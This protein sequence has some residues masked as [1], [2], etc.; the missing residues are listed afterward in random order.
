ME[1]RVVV[2]YAD[3]DPVK[4]I[5]RPGPHQIY[6][7][8]RIVVE[9]RKLPLLRP[10]EIRV[11]M[12]YAGICGTDIHLVTAHPDTGYIRCSAPAQITAAGRIIGHEGI[13]KVLEVGSQVRHIQPGACVTFESII[14]CHYCDECRRGD[15]N[16]CRHA[17]LLGLEKDGL[18]GDI[19]DVP[20]MI[21]H[22]VSDIAQ[23]EKG[24]RAAACIE[25]AGV[26][27]V[28]CQNTHVG[29]GDVV[30]IF[31]AGPI[32]LF[33]AMLSKFVFGASQVHMVEPVLFRRKLAEK[34]SNEIYD[35]DEFF[36]HGPSSIDVV[37]EASG[38]M[39][40]ISRVFRRLNANG[41]V[42]ILGRSGE[43]LSLDAVDHMITNAVS[44][45]GSRG[46][47]GGAFAKILTLCRNGRI[48]LDD[49]VTCI[50]NGPD[51]I[52]DLLNLPEKILE[53]NCKVLVNFNCDK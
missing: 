33:A 4:G 42:A 18:F 49:A 7:N 35:I 3:I 34:W 25:P 9:K 47:L 14:V 2:V 43:P 40:N 38:N 11:K 31:G 29:A 21:T 32:G 39:A 24:M 30:A 8:P 45:I 6:K 52:S 16:Q 46:H 48:S 27:Y 13:G 17:L 26:A 41:R 10:D 12:L 1:S 51:E 15:F 23:N 19:V 5:A 50:I 20:S 53:E 37:I 36:E 22:D 44:I 28:A